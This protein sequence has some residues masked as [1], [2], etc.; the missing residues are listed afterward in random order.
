M[1][2]RHQRRAQAARERD[3]QAPSDTPIIEGL[4]LNFSRKVI[5]AHAPQVQRDEMKNA[6]FAG[7]MSLFTDVIMNLSGGDVPQEADLARLDKVDTELKEYFHDYL[8]RHF[9]GGSMQ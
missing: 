3:Q 5:P 9:P 4:W 2:N 1:M 8:S 7:A 6:F